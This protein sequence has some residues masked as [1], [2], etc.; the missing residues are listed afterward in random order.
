VE[1]T[2]E[3]PKRPARS[4]NVQSVVR[5]LTLFDGVARREE[6]GLVELAKEAGLQPSTAH[7]LM[8]TLVSCGYVDQ[9]PSTN[10]YRMGL[11][12]FGL[13]G[14]AEHRVARLR[15]ATR[16]HLERVR[17]ETDETTNLVVLEG[18]TAVYVDQAESSHAMRMFAEI[19]RRVPAH[20]SAAGKAI[21]AFE[22]P[23][24]LET[25]FSQ[26]PFSRRTQH[27]ITTAAALRRALE[28]VR[29]DGYATDDEE[30]EE[31]VCCIA[32]PIRDPSGVAVAAISVSAP[33]A[34]MQRFGPGEL[35]E[36]LAQHTDDIS[37]KLG[38]FAKA[39]DGK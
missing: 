38:Y 31:G 30:Y 2:S 12:L 27:T 1:P 25:L 39:A 34:R 26:T 5:A 15:A 13:V 28:R 18:A 14:G 22:P 24:H 35:A 10:R 21:L 19:G 4:S 33:L 17:D 23:E 29:V 7:R 32:A 11:M 36:I 37:G 9:D 3:T 16:Q 8:A 20:A 6:V